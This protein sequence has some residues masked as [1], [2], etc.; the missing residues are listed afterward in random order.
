MLSAHY[1]NPVNFSHDLME[2]AKNGLDR[3]LTAVDNLRHLSENA[4]DVTMTE[5]E[6]KIIA[7]IDDIYKKFEDS[8]DDDFNKQTQYQLYLNL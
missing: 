7:S 8:M 1:R 5:D 2:S 4:K 3:I 6:K